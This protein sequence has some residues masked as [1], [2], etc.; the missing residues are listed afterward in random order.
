MTSPIFQIA[1]K[2]LDLSPFFIHAPD[3]EKNKKILNFS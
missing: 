3:S 2:V 1:I